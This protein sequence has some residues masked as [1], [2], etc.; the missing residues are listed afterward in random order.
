MEHFRGS[1]VP[2][3]Q[4]LSTCSADLVRQSASQFSDFQSDESQTDANRSIDRTIRGPKPSQID[5]KP[6][7]I[8]PI[9]GH[10]FVAIFPPLLLHRTAKSW[11]AGIWADW[12]A[13]FHDAGVFRS[14]LPPF[15]IRRLSYQ[16]ISVMPQS[17]DV[18]L[19]TLTLTSR[20][21]FPAHKKKKE[22]KENRWLQRVFAHLTPPH[23]ACPPG[24]M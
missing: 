20:A 16:D 11:S 10:G 3:P 1:F 7:P 24:Q 18:R 14:I 21:A 6:A 13:D 12:Q 9:C 22:R 8:K 17:S 4:V 23:S 2:H 15:K 19:L 5:F